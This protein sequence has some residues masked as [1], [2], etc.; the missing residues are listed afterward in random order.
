MLTSTPVLQIYSQVLKI[1]FQFFLNNFWEAANNIT[2]SG[3]QFCINHLASLIAFQV[4]VMVLTKT[5]FLRYCK[6]RVTVLKKENWIQLDELILA[7]HCLVIRPKRHSGKIPG[8]LWFDKS[9][10][11]IYLKDWYNI[12]VTI[13]I[14]FAGKS[15]YKLHE[16]KLKITYL[17][18]EVVRFFLICSVSTKV[19]AS[20]HHSSKQ[21]YGYFHVYRSR[22]S[23]MHSL[24]RSN[25]VCNNH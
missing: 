19:N 21:K 3:F 10:K 4:N 17:Y 18:I 16:L 20:F 22:K 8:I 12:W 1:S 11:C 9:W 14:Y 13:Q 25:A 15:A 24:L 6:V 23:S 2:C 7:R 5:D